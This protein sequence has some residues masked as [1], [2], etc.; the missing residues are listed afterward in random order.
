MLIAIIA[1]MEQEVVPLKARLENM[2]SE[3]IDGFAYYKGTLQGKQVVV[4]KSGIGKVNAA[5]SASH[6]MQCF[7]PD[8]V[9][10]TGSAGGC[11]PSVQVGDIIISNKVCHHDVD[12]TAFN[13]A[14][15]QLP[16]LPTYFMP[17]KE[18]VSLA[19][20]HL[21]PL[22]NVIYHCGLI[23]SGDQ[24]IHDVDR[25]DR[26][27]EM[28]PDIMACEMEAAAIAQVC[29]HFNIPFVV[30][31]A[32]SDIPGEDNATVFEQFLVQVA[33]HYAELLVGMIQA[34]KEI[35]G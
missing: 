2:T 26:I 33:N 28:F 13:Y 23:A 14:Y 30:I 8:Y 21:K 11:G 1:A 15:G 20:Q 9:I 10:N 27:K 32:I 35:K 7:K 3:H 12:L 4:L 19:I 6:L 25:I 16:E 5:I 29:H 24:F 18:L 22:K 17:S 31:R 34:M